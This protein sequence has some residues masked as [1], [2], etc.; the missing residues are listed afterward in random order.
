MSGSSS[1]TRRCASRAGAA[2]L[3]CVA[4]TILLKAGFCKASASIDGSA[5]PD[6]NLCSR[7]KSQL[8]GAGDSS[9]GS[10]H[11]LLPAGTNVGAQQTTSM[12]E[13]EL[14]RESFVNC[15]A[16]QLFRCDQ[17]R[18]HLAPDDASGTPSGCRGSSYSVIHIRA[19]SRRSARRSSSISSAVE[20]LP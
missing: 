12:T 15:F 8:G 11:T 4:C 1:T 19:R 6:K 13:Q 7:P 3:V 17:R 18:C 14:R 9:T 5:M 2:V 10:G 16:R 20:V